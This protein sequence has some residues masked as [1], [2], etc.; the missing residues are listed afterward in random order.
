MHA[1]ILPAGVWP[2]MLTPFTTDG[3]IDWEAL[4][5]MIDW[6]LEQGID[7]LFAVCLSS[8]MAACEGGADRPGG[9]RE[10]ER[11]QRFLSLAEKVVAQ[12]HPASAKRFLALRGLRL[13]S[14]CRITV[15]QTAPSEDQAL[16]LLH[17]R[18]AV[19]ECAAH[20]AQTH[21]RSSRPSPWM[22]NK[23]AP[24]WRWQQCGAADGAAVLDADPYLPPTPNED[25]P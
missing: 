1:Y 24:P 13:S 7:G 17:L 16:T 14:T 25:S 22:Q 6:Y 5:L 11:L 2:V 19:S 8:E 3:A 12:G 15:E 10:A 21:D 4:D 20:F 9:P 23:H 18:D